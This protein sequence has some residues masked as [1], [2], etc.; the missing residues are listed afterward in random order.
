M[1][2]CLMSITTPK[3]HESASEA[4]DDK[5]EPCYSVLR[6]EK[7]GCR[8]DNDNDSVAQAVT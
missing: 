5:P 7:K 1:S 8:Y 3:P 6:I 4:I 2:E